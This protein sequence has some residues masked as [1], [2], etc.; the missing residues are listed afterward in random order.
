[1]LG[2]A[3]VKQKGDGYMKKLVICLVLAVV[4][5]CPQISAAETA[6]ES[7]S[8]ESETDTVSAEKVFYDVLSEKVTDIQITGRGASFYFAYDNLF[9]NMGKWL[10]FSPH[11][12]TK[13]IGEYGV[14]EKVAEALGNIQACVLDFSD[15]DRYPGLAVVTVDVGE[16]FAGKHVD[17]YRYIQEEAG[18]RLEPVLRQYRVGENGT[19]ELSLT[20]AKDYII[21]ESTGASAL[22]SRVDSLTP[23]AMLSDGESGSNAGVIAVVVICAVLVAG[24]FALIII[25]QAR[26]RSFGEERV[27]TA[28]KPDAENRKNR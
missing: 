5:L 24:T 28:R 18:D 2:L 6:V 14:S 15:G 22:G 8:Y 25:L 7:F 1:M 23:G 27:R 10:D 3:G 21:L 13:T 16:S 20:A 12:V 17:V 19:I 9:R 26:R 11:V 4:L